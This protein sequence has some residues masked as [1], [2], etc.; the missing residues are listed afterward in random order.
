MIRVVLA[1]DQ[2]LDWAG[3]DGL[4]ELTRER[5]VALS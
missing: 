5:E 3:S 4:D 1:D 2:E